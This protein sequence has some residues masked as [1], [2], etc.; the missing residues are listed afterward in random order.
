MA[1]VVRGQKEAGH[2]RLV[3]GSFNKERELTYK[4][5]LGQQQ[6]ECIPSPT[7]QILKV[8]IEGSMGGSVD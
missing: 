3:G 1:A 6:E 2:S 4:E 5:C 7:H 8:Y